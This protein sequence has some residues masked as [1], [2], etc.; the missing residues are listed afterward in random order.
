[1]SKTVW[2]ESQIE[3]AFALVIA[4]VVIA[5][6]LLVKGCN[7]PAYADTKDNL[8]SLWKFDCSGNKS[9]SGVWVTQKNDSVWCY[10]RAKSSRPITLK[11]CMI[12]DSFEGHAGVWLVCIGN[13]R[14]LFTDLNWARNGI[15]L[16][17]IFG[18]K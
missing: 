18:E 9:I 4:I 2:K 1:M 11:D 3:S 8:E 5:I 10:P 13:N 7:S 12:L 14:E 16:G 17:E 6:I 15:T